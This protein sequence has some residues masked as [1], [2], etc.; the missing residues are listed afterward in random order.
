VQDAEDRSNSDTSDEDYD[1]D[2][3]SNVETDNDTKG[4]QR[5]KAPAM[6]A[7][8]IEDIKRKLGIDEESILQQFKEM[9]IYYHVQRLPKDA[10]DA[11]SSKSGTHH[12]A[13]YVNSSK[14]C[15]NV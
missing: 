2:N 4:Y 9:N 3:D 10:E 13:S 14:R 11:T 7:T 5:S 1:P 15:C 6:S 12:T 8:D